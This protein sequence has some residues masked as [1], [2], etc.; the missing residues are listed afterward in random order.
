MAT[1]LPRR[2]GFV[3]KSCQRLCAP[4]SSRRQIALL[5][6]TTSNEQRVQQN[7]RRFLS[8]SA[9][10]R[11]APAAVLPRDRK[12]KQ[13]EQ[14]PSEDPYEIPS[15]IE[16]R[17]IDPTTEL[18]RLKEAVSRLTSLDTVPDNGDVLEVLLDCYRLANCL[19]FG[20]SK[21]ANEVSMQPGE[22]LSQ[23]ILRDLSEDSSNQ[24]Q[25]FVPNKE[26]S[27]P[28]RE[29]A[30]RTIAELIYT[31]LRD[32]KVYVSDEALQMYV[33]IQCLLGKPEYLPEM[34]HLHAHKKIPHANTKPITYSEPWPKLPKYAI[35]LSLADAAL[36]AAILKK[37]LPLAIAIIDTTVATP[38]W[39]AHRILSKAALP[40]GVVGATPLVAYAGADWVAHWQNTMDIEMSKYTAIAGALAYIGTL[41]TIGFVAITTSN[42]QM[43]RVVWRPGTKLADRWIREHE[44]AFYDRLALAWGFQDKSRWGEEQGSD[45]HRLRDECGLRDMI[46]DK[47]D[48]MEGMQ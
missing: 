11:V 44:R 45:W 18:T 43:Q 7:A 25:V 47:T 6:K 13:P 35:P 36:E 10:P 24:D 46:L 41:S 30:S 40:L 17:Q 15:Q 33:R 28:F 23:A 12:I 26:L 31:L 39:R 38:A 2:T 21:G 16:L 32:P 1:I 9:I 19:V 5:A 14:D 42:D 20:V 29:N 27:A 4:Q 48:L 37:N 22:D 34:F 3:C 8:Q